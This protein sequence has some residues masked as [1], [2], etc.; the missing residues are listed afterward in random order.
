MHEV[1][2]ILAVRLAP[3]SDNVVSIARLFQCP[4]ASQLTKF[5]LLQRIGFAESHPMNAQAV[6][7]G[8]SLIPMRGF[9]RL[10]DKLSLSRSTVCCINNGSTNRISWV[11]LLS[12]PYA[13]IPAVFM[14]LA[15]CI[16]RLAIAKALLRARV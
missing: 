5:L 7:P 6:L 13:M 16:G 14:L 10:M 12:L 9:M 15:R 1:E 4:I 3:L 2:A 11:I 8:C